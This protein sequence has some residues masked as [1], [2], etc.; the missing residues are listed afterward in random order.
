MAIKQTFIKKLTISV[1]LFAYLNAFEHGS[2]KK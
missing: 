2:L 1:M